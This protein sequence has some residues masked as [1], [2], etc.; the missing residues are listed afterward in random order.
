MLPSGSKSRVDPRITIQP[1]TWRDLAEL[2]R[3][4]RLCFAED[5]WPL[6][7]LIAVLTWPEIVRLKAVLDGAMVGFI[8][9][10][11]RPQENTAWIATLGVLPAY[12]RQGIG[13]ALLEA[14]EARLPQ[15]RLCLCVRD[16]NTAAIRLYAKAGYRALETWQRYYRDGE[17]A[18]VM[19]KI[20]ATKGEQVAHREQGEAERDRFA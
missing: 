4:E 13:L 18:L 8:A 19:E 2:H 9:G 12:R 5:S 16:S 17:D 1:A 6:L 3:V 10:D 14:C 15:R 11:P 20:R 7:D